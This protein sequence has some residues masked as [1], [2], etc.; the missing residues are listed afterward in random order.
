MALFV[1][2]EEE[3]DW[4]D[5][6]SRDDHGVSAVPALREGQAMFEEAGLSPCYLVD[7]PILDSADAIAILGEMLAK[8]TASVGAHLHPWVTP[9][10]IETVSSSN[11]YAGNLPEEME[12]QKIRTV[13][14]MITE[15]LGTPPLAYRAGRYGIGPN[16]FRILAEEG[17]V[18]D[19]SIR[20]MFDYSSD[21][22]P[23][24]RAA[25]LHPSRVGPDG[26]I[27]ELPLTTVLIGH[28]RGR[29]RRIYSWGEHVPKLRSLLSRS[30][31]AQRIP[32]T[33]EGIPADKACAAIDVA[34]NMGVRLL[35]FSFHSPSLA[36]G[37]TPYVRDAADLKAFYGWW[38]TIFAHCR[39]RGV[40]PASLDQILE[41][42]GVPAGARLASAPVAG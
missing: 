20:A 39:R 15:R 32:L 29:G 25:S 14:A 38:E 5:S 21:G 31:L 41:A 7:T 4:S 16:T 28:L 13:R 8:G 12:R 11:S 3:F 40:A 27:V 35:N 37:H 22:G 9:P 18:C 2:T 1:D 26:A 17:F 19:T 34:L 30:R 10:F 6:L 24:F 36:I 23:D 33:P 42:A